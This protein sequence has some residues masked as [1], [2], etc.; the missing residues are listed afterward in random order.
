MA[1]KMTTIESRLRHEGYSKE[2]EYFS[3]FNRVL[4]EQP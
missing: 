1:N 2:E 3:E 4:I